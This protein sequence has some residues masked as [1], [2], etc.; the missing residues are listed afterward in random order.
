MPLG[1]FGVR[2][3]TLEVDLGDLRED[4]GALGMNLHDKG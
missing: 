2:L 3:S 1:R 4:L